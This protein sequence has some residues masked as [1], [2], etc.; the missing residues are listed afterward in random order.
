MR[1]K[2]ERK[3]KKWKESNLD[4][5]VL[6]SDH[7]RRNC[8]AAMRRGGCSARARNAVV[9][10]LNNNR[11][12]AGKAWEQSQMQ[13]VSTAMVS[14]AVCRIQ[15]KAFQRSSRQR[16]GEERWKWQQMVVYLFSVIQREARV[17]FT[18]VLRSQ[19]SDQLSPV[20]ETSGMCRSDWWPPFFSTSIPP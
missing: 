6:K 7:S 15:A 10:G 4:P 20:A 14:S 1:K 13:R 3:G 18:Q 5:F 9:F 17:W 19:Y 12:K 2:W 8:G 11:R 16:W